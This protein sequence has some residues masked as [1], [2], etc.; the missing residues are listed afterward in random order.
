MNLLSGWLAEDDMQLK[1]AASLAIGNFACNEEHCTEL[2]DKDVSQV[3]IG[4]LKTHQ[5]RRIG[6]A[7]R[8]DKL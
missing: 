4:L 6:L 1:V 7:A 8:V 3:L 2:M 5:V